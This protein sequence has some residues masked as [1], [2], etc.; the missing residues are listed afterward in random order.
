MPLVSS[1]IFFF[2]IAISGFINFLRLYIVIPKWKQLG[3]M[4]SAI[5]AFLVRDKRFLFS[6]YWDEIVLVLAHFLLPILFVLC[7]ILYRKYRKHGMSVLWLYLFLITGTIEVFFRLTN[8][9][10][11]V[12][13]D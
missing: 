5:D 1:L 10:D 3:K 12:M 8:A 4:P 7:F 6:D 9:Y 13:A 2:T 11:Y